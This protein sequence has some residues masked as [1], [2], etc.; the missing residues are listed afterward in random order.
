MRQKNPPYSGW[1]KDWF[2]KPLPK[3]PYKLAY[4][5]KRDALNVF[6]EH[7][8]AIV[9]DYGGASMKHSPESFEAINHKFDIKG[10]RR[11]DTIARAVWWAL[12]GPGPY[13]LEDIDIH[14][15]NETAPAIYNQDGLI[16]EIPDYVEEARLA[17]LEAEH[18]KDLELPEEDWSPEGVPF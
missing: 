1:Q 14:L 9:D 18:Y 12:R 13:Y 17:E 11:V 7:N 15:L 10:K 4:K 5:R 2:R 8:R 3:D 6:L 16:F